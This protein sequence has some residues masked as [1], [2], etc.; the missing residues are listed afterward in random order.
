MI[1][2][3]MAIWWHD[4]NMMTL[5][6]Y[7]DMMMIIHWRMTCQASHQGALGEWKRVGFA[8]VGVV[9]EHQCHRLVFWASLSL[10][11]NW[12]S[13]SLYCTSL[14]FHLLGALNYG[15]GCLPSDIDCEFVACH[16]ILIV[17]Q[18]LAIQF[19]LW[20]CCLPSDIRFN[21]H[22]LGYSLLGGN[23]EVVRVGKGQVERH[24]CLQIIW[25]TK[26]N[27]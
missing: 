19:K 21:V 23:V 16:P 13:L 5:W 14:A 4:G 10:N 7:D 3:M 27:N 24:L 20:I 12:A 1:D 25:S 11:R 22:L 6:Q 15:N 26:E 9:T 17:N 8:S 18:F 2:D